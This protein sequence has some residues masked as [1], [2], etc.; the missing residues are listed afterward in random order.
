[1]LFERNASIQSKDNNDQTPLSLAAEK[2]NLVMAKQL[3]ERN[4]DVHFKDKYGRRSLLLTTKNR[5]E[6][7][8]KLL[9]E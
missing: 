1:M 7:V 8:V 4:A 2:G 9:L 6:S 5:H 3:L